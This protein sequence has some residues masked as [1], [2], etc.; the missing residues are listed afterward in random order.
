MCFKNMSKRKRMDEK[1]KTAP[2]FI[3]IFFFLAG[4]AAAVKDDA[5]GHFK[6]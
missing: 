4:K 2:F 6:A 3:P 1:R 5:A